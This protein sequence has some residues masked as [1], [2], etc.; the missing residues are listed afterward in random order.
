MLC[1]LSSQNCCIA[2]TGRKLT[3]DALVPRGVSECSRFLAS[4]CHLRGGVQ[5]MLE[6]VAFGAVVDNLRA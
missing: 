4:N 6:E 3:D 1:T 5:V 2:A